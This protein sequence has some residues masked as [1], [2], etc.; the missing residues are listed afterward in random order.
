M[1]WLFFM[2]WIMQVNTP[3]LA[4]IST[5]TALVFTRRTR[6]QFV[7]YLRRSRWLLLVLLLMHAYS[8]PGTPLWPALGAYS[9]SQ[10]GLSSGLLQSWRLMLVLAMLAVLMTRLS[11]EAI[12]MGIYTLMAPLRYVGLEPE[13]MAVRVWLTM[14]YAE[15]L[16]ED[17]RRVSFRQRLQQLSNPPAA[18][19]DMVQSLELPLQR[20]SWLDYACIASVVV[21]GI[22]VR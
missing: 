1:L 12:L 14:R 7:R 10:I 17:A 8:L 9:P 22:W 18:G 5:V 21:L 3:I 16:M 4:G 6:Q 2:V 15:A 13:R 19:D 11:R 20:S